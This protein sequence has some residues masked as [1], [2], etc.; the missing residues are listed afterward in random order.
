MTVKY[1]CVAE[2]PSISKS[3]TQILSSGSFNTR[4][5]SSKFIKNYDF[6]YKMSGYNGRQVDF[7]VTAV[8]GHLTTAEFPK[9]MRKW[10]SCD[11]VQLF[12]GRV[13]ISTSSSMS[14]IENNLKSEAR[15]ASH[16]M[17]WTDCDREG[18][19]IGSEI[20]N[21]CR[22]AN[23][24]IEVIRAKFS[25]II[26]NQIHHAARNPVMLDM[27]QVR[28]VE[29]RIELDLRIG[30]AFTRL[31]T[32]NL[33]KQVAELDG[34][35]ISYGPCQFPTLGFVVD[36][37]QRIK[38]FIT[39]NFWYIFLSINHREENGRKKAVTFNWKRDRLFDAQIAFLLYERCITNPT[40]RVT[41]VET[42]PHTK[43]KP[44]PLTTVELQKS[45]SRLLKLSPKQVLDIA[46]K[47]YQQGFLS[48]PRTETDQYDPSFNFESLIEKQ[49]AN[50]TW[51]E[52]AQSLQFDRF[53][54]PRNGKKND[55]A[56]PPIHPTAHAPSLSG[57]EKRVYELITRRF[58]AS[59]S[60]DAKGKNTTAELEMAGEIFKAS[61]SVLIEK[62]Y[63]EVYIYEKWSNQTI[64]NF[65][66]GEVFQPSI[67]ELREG[68]TTPPTL[69]TE[70]DLVS[71]MD[72]N[73]IGTDAT[74]A[75]H[76]HKIIDREYVMEHK[77]GST[78]YLVPSTLGVA[79]VEGYNK[80]NFDKSFA[81]PQLR[82]ENEEKMNMIGEGIAQKSDVLLESI[83]QY[84]DIYNRSA[85]QFAT[86]VNSVKHYLQNADAFD[87]NVIAENDQN[88]RG[89]DEGGGGF[90]GFNNNNNNDNSDSDMDDAPPPPRGRGRPRGTT[91]QRTTGASRTSRSNGNASEFRV[92]QMYEPPTKSN[93]NHKAQP[94]K[95]GQVR[96]KCDLSAKRFVTSQGANKGRAFWKCPNTS[97]TA[98]CGFWSWEDS[99]DSP[100][101]SAQ[102]VDDSEED[103]LGDELIADDDG[104]IPY[105]DL[106]SRNGHWPARCTNPTT[107]PAPKSTS[108][109][110][111]KKS[112]SS[113]VGVNN[114]KKGDTCYKCNK[115]GH[116]ASNCP[117]EGKPPAK[118]KTYTKKSTQKKQRRT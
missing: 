61:G 12:N 5:T 50:S 64:P 97:K 75:E 68:K 55:K 35:L 67:C 108:T 102:V 17:I 76:I 33:S 60:K 96:C 7:T 15:R 78:K 10:H 27:K 88:A 14:A 105:C 92:T 30:A 89:E 103:L 57:N 18:E 109:V 112:S 80:M 48:Y 71:L 36:Q 21:V 91:S 13:E 85:L 28:A 70:A 52:Y 117:N 82:R 83:N 79:L 113:G 62:N 51:G 98:Q 59:C 65:E 99:M 93:S 84:R 8:A 74:I 101:T 56:H 63:L 3:I 45:G 116:W 54:R 107:G 115:K 104:E 9:E 111:S 4:S 2:K 31:M 41:K 43:Y 87:D 44:Y 20:V 46:E 72:K 19:H 34:K 110:K 39:E 38:D 53:D 11:P 40:A 25:A 26:P 49:T 86:L 24:R 42:K 106:C 90:G 32:L 1:L 66:Q 73:G 114:T 94:P 22:Q 100:N 81:K 23:P 16:L 95:E 37:Y 6:S 118:R 58:L 47:L 29:T 77:L 69:L